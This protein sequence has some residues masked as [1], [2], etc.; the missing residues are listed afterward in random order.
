MC[1]S[2]NLFLLLYGIILIHGD[3]FVCLCRN[4]SCISFIICIRIMVTFPWFCCCI[5]ACV[6][7]WLQF[8]FLDLFFL[9]IIFFRNILCFLVNFNYILTLLRMVNYSLDIILQYTYLSYLFILFF[10]MILVKIIFPFAQYY[11]TENFIVIYYG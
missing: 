7:C 1:F 6:F 10:C 3:F 11:Q 4:F 9:F 5:R 2:Q 8:C